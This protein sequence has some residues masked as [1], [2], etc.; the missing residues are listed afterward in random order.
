MMKRLLLWPSISPRPQQSM[1]S[2]RT[3]PR[4][5]PSLRKPLP[6]NR[7][8]TSP[9]PNGRVAPIARGRRGPRVCR[10]DS[11]GLPSNSCY[12]WHQPRCLRAARACSCLCGVIPQLLLVPS[13]SNTGPKS[14]I[15]GT[16]APNRSARR[17]EAAQAGF[18]PKATHGVRT[19][20]VPHLSPLGSQPHSHKPHSRFA[21]F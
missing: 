7:E 12:G 16:D 1:R 13:F 6:E 2:S 9:S 20:C 3:S 14:L 19:F 15:K 18:P 17:L 8:G 21:H 11:S 10:S 4:P 5:G